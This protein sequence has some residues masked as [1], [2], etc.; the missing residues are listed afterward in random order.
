MTKINEILNNALP[1]WLDFTETPVDNIEW[2]LGGYNIKSMHETLGKAQNLDHT[3]LT[4]F[5]ILRACIYKYIN[6]SSFNLSS[7]IN[8]DENFIKKIKELNILTK[9]IDDE[10]GLVE[11]RNFQETVKKAVKHYN[12]NMDE[13]NPIIDNEYGLAYLRRDAIK[14]L[15]KLKEYQFLQGVTDTNKCAYNENVYEFWNIN[16]LLRLSL[17]QVR[18]GI[19]LCMIQDPSLIYQSYFVF[20]IRN[21]GTLTILTDKTSWVHPRQKHMSRRPD[22]DFK[23]RAF[24]WWFPYELLNFEFNEKGDIHIPKREGLVLYQQEAIKLCP[25]NKLNPYTLIWL[26][27]MFDLIRDK[28]WVKMNRT[29][30]LC[31]TGEMI[32]EN[33]TLI[34]HAKALVPVENY[35]PIMVEKLTNEDIKEGKLDDQWGRKPDGTNSWLESRFEDQIPDDIYNF[36]GDVKDNLKLL[37]GKCDNT[38][39]EGFNRGISSFHPM[40]KPLYDTFDPVEFGTEEDILKDR[41]WFARYNKAQAIDILAEK[42]YEDKKEEIENWIRNAILNNMENII[43]WCIKGEF[44]SKTTWVRS[45]SWDNTRRNDEKLSNIINQKTLDQS[46]T[47]FYTKFIAMSGYFNKYTFKYDHNKHHYVCIKNN[48]VGSIFSVFII[49]NAQNLADMLSLEIKDLPDV[50]QH[51][52]KDLRYSGNSILDRIDPMD[53]VVH[54][55]WNKM[56]IIPT[57]VFSKR[58]YKKRR[59]EL[60]LSVEYPNIFDLNIY[61]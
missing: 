45:E 60:G 11:V 53:W 30:E 3:G 39:I 37:E 4:P 27:M 7:I 56:R 47:N 16:S 26:T 61:D 44:L 2:E 34:D 8:N 36:V 23:A 21:G 38:L 15:E 55:Q 25:L 50:L 18:S 29:K 59:K 9:M 54:N 24:E 17:N 51:Y 14:G 13:L 46:H 20:L 19:T 48:S 28:Y 5:M 49:D 12:G 6:S 40:A 57:I 35:K 31:Y 1:M 58:Y 33:K 32:R 41:K 43:D 52:H 42:E 22:K 10:R